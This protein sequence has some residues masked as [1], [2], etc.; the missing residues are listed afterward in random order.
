MNQSDGC[1]SEG[2]RLLNLWTRFVVVLLEVNKIMLN[3]V[4][5]PMAA[6]YQC[7]IFSPPF[8]S[9]KRIHFK[10]ELLPFVNAPQ[11]SY[12]VLKKELHDLYLNLK[13]NVLCHI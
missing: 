2:G 3:S 9:L 8:A 4:H 5:F 13:E 6:N 7:S 10:P 12:F 1:R 11:F